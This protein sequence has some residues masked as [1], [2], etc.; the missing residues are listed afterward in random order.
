[1]LKESAKDVDGE[2]EDDGE[3]SGPKEP[4]M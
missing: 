1:V 2:C 4:S 3:V